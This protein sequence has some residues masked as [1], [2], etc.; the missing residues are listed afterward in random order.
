MKKALNAALILLIAAFTVACKLA[1]IV[2]EGG[3]VQ[4]TGSGTCVAGVVCIVEVTDTS[5]S[6]T[7]RAVPGASWYFHKW[8]SGNR[9]LCGGSADPECLMSFEGAENSAPITELVAS[10]EVFFLMPVFKQTPPQVI[11]PEDRPVRVDGKEWLQPIHFVN[12]SFD[13]ISQ[14]CPERMCVG[15]LPGS[16]VDLTGYFWAS[17]KDVQPLFDFYQETGRN[18]LDDFIYT[19]AEKDEELDQAVNLNLRVILSDEPTSEGWLHVA[20]IYDGQPFEP[21]KEERGIGVSPFISAGSSGIDQG[22]WFWRTL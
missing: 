11:V 7:F 1:V 14:V 19:L 22:A 5:F 4:S 15:R 9:F 21:S 18:I 2:V 13:Q 17:S 12:Y 8:N 3:E 20:G 10:S 6:E 16:N